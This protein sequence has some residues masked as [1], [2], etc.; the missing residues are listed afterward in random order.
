MAASQQKLIHLYAQIEQILAH[1]RALRGEAEDILETSEVPDSKSQ[2]GDVLQSTEHATVTIINTVGSINAIVMESSMPEEKKNEVSALIAHIYEACGFQDI[3]GQR[4]KKVMERLQTLEEQLAR[5]S[6]TAKEQVL[7]A[8][9]AKPKDALMNG[10]QL[11]GAA[12]NQQQIDQL[13]Q[14]K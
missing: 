13:F 11:S 7:P 14:E 3:S 2:L 5:L 6:S 8:A 12:P 4:I 10:P 1:F 9:A